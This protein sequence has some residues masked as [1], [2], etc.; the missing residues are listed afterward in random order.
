MMTESRLKTQALKESRVALRKRVAV[1]VIAE[2]ARRIL[3]KAMEW[4][5]KST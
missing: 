1:R 2:G 3:V 5:D 4:R